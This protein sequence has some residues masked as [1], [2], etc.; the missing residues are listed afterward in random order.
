MCVAEFQVMKHLGE[1]MEPRC[2]NSGDER[3][4]TSLTCTA[5]LKNAVSV[6]VRRKM[7]CKDY[8]V[9]VVSPQ[10][11]RIDLYRETA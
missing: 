11:Q 8:K 1:L 7:D 6:E 2:I 4:K 3:F 10:Q 5:T 9:K